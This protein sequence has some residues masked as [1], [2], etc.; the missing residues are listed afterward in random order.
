MVAVMHHLMGAAEIGARLGLSRQ[1]VQQLIREPGFPKPE[2]ELAMGKVWD[3]E[4]IEAWIA[5]NR[6]TM[7]R[8]TDGTIPPPPARRLRPRTKPNPGRP[9][10]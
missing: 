9:P 3:T 8:R 6:P 5:E 1:R 10:A 2:H 7:A 4:S